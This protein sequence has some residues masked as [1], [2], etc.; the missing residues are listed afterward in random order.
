[1][2]FR[3][4]GLR[5]ICVLAP[6][7]AVAQPALYLKTRPL[8]EAA[9]SPELREVPQRTVLPGRAHWLVQ[10]H[11]APTAED[12][13]QLAERGAQVLSYVPEHA[14]LIAAAE[15]FN[16]EGLATARLER[17]VHVDKL[18]PQVDDLDGSV[19]SAYLVEFH[20]D[21]DFASEQAVL[22]EAGVRVI[23]S[24]SVPAH[25]QVVLGNR[26]QIE[27]LALWDEVVYISPASEDLANG[28][29]VHHCSGA[30]T[31]F[32][33]LASA[34]S[35]VGEGWAPGRGSANLLYG[36]GPLSTRSNVDQARVR[37]EYLRAMNEWARVVAL[38]WSETSVL[39]GPR[40]MTLR[41]GRG[42]DSML[43]RTFDGPGRTLAYAYFPSP[44]NP[45]PI[46]GDVYLDDDENWQFGA[47]IDVYSVL[48]HEL[49]HSLGLNHLDQPGNVMNAFYRRATELQSGDIATIR[50][51][52]ATRTSTPTAPSPTPTP[53]PAPT[54][55]A[56]PSDRLA[57][58]LTII[59]PALTTFSTSA[60]S[61]LVRGTARDN[62]GVTQ[63]SFANSTGAQ[64]L[65]QG[66]A[67]WQASVPLVVGINRITIQARDAAGNTATRTLVVT[68]RQQ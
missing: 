64:G 23:A 66:I 20:A 25:H 18:S 54:P 65:T 7:F 15:D 6:A 27:R 26:E 59:S 10:F 56:V 50:T 48:L 34:A 8:G 30:M 57:P 47:D 42:N 41:F 16:A 12:V 11:S 67:N 39:N 36:F 2:L 13:A 60:A 14:F 40:T 53:A 58:T 45:E 3:R 44:P 61:L 24:A 68:R 5:L 63:V 17:W 33:P 37:A 28:S 38:T 55:P 52:Y 31:E 32:A 43:P 51:L 46:A 19:E 1:M 62:I 29:P 4:L 35:T 9:L 49:G 22:A 21:V